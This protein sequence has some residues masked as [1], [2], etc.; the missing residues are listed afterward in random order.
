MS[1]HEFQEG[2]QGEFLL[3]AITKSPGSLH[4]SVDYAAAAG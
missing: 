4:I 3:R 2:R 1:L